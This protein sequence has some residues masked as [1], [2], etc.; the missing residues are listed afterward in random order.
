MRFGNDAGIE[1]LQMGVYLAPKVGVPR[2]WMGRIRVLK[3][4]ALSIFIFFS[5]YYFSDDSR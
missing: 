4:E 3:Y 2:V 5:F 1:K